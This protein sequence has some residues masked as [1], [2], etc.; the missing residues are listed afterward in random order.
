MFKVVRVNFLKIRYFGM[1]NLS[2]KATIIYS[3][4]VE[5]QESLFVGYRILCFT[6]L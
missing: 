4:D 5:M 3:I 6:P 1:A 2:L